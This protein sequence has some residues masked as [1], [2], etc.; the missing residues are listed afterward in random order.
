M[1][2]IIRYAFIA[3]LVFNAGLAKADNSS[4]KELSSVKNIKEYRMSK[5]EAKR[6]VS[7]IKEIRRMDKSS[8]SAQQKKD[9][10]NEVLL[11]KEQLNKGGKAYVLVLSTTAIIIIILLII[12]L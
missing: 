6:L 12:L 9:L 11:I 1:K 7:R 8:L 2:T 5:E 3:I 10:R 4:S